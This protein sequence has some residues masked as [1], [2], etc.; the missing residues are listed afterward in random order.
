LR[1][2]QQTYTKSLMEQ[3]DCILHI[4]GDQTSSAN[5]LEIEDQKLHQYLQ[6]Y[7]KELHTHT[8]S[9]TVYL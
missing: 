7:N 3:I 4:T 2:I 5:K 8:L 9:T 1:V 6:Q